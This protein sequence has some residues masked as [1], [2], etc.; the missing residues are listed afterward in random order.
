MGPAAGLRGPPLAGRRVAVEIAVGLPLGEPSVQD[1]LDVLHNEVDGHCGA[2]TAQ[3]QRHRQGGAQAQG[4]RA[5][6]AWRHS[7]VQ[8]TASATC[9]QVTQPPQAPRGPVWPPSQENSSKRTMLGNG[10][11]EHRGFSSD[12]QSHSYMKPSATVCKALS[13]KGK[14]RWDSFCS[15]RNKLHTSSN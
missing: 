15:M 5:H 7:A 14:I 10:R 13:P 8:V 1:V 6:R 3:R 4:R 2:E 11:P 12:D 9:W